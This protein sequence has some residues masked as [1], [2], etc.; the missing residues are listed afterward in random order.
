MLLV[1]F[2]GKNRLA[3][4]VPAGVDVIRDRSFSSAVITA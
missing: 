2:C 4:V 3:A 1:Y